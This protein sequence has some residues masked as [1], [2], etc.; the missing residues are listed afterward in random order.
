VGIVNAKR[1][2]AENRAFWADKKTP[3]KQEM[4]FAST[5]TKKPGDPPGKYVEAF[6]GSDI[7]TNPPATNEAVER[8]ARTITR[9]VDEMPAAAVLAEID[10]LVDIR[11]LEET[12][13]EEGIKKFADPLKA[14]LSLIELKRTALATKVTRHWK[15]LSSVRMMGWPT[16]ELDH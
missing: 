1:I 6:A 8:S 5:G 7:E 14:L 4:I 15:E 16:A 9:H 12:L 3:L 10:R 11:Q 2:W 13:M